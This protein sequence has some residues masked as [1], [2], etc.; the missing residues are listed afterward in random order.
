MTLP[1][2]RRR[3]L[4]AIATLTPISK[5]ESSRGQNAETEMQS[6]DAGR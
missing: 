1:Q 6:K 5:A 2:A 4:A 3:V